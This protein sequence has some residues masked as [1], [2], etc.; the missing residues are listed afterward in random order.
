M[1]F[2][3]L[4]GRTKCNLVL[5]PEKG[6]QKEKYKNPKVKKS[7]SCEIVKSNNRI[8]KKSK[9]S[10]M[11]KMRNIKKIYGAFENNIC[12]QKKYVFNNII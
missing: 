9:R 4:L 8:I 7:K 11:Q 6:T 10:H 3:L 5:R 1:S 12:K 2:A